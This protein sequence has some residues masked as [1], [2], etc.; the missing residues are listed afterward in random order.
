MFLAGIKNR[1]GTGYRW[2]SVLFNNKVYDNIRLATTK[3]AM[4]KAF[5]EEPILKFNNIYG[6]VMV[7]EDEYEP[8]STKYILPGSD[9]ELMIDGIGFDSS[10]L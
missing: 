7:P 4:F 2:Y 6:N 8:N 1:I 3:E 9:L 5:L 10:I